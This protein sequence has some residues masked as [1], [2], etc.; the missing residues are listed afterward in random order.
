MT[1]EAFFVWSEVKVSA[2]GSPELKAM[3]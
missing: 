1:E 2:T 3:A